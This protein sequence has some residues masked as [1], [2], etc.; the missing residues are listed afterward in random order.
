MREGLAGRRQRGKGS[1]VG[2]EFHLGF[3][4][5]DALAGLDPAGGID[6]GRGLLHVPPQPADGAAKVIRFPA[7]G[8]K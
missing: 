1:F 7:T 5:V 2:G 6:G 4:D 8:L 3:E